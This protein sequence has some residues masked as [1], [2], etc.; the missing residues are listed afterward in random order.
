MTPL[1]DDRH[2]ARRHRFWSASAVRLVARKGRAADAPRP[3]VVPAPAVPPE[4]DGDDLL[5][6]LREAGL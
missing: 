4:D 3:A 1:A 2:P 5:R 6:R